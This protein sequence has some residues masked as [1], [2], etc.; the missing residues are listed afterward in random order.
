M[1]DQPHL[2][3][4]QPPEDTSNLEVI[5]A[6]VAAVGVDLDPVEESA[7][8]KLTA[9]G[10]EVVT[11][12]LTRDIIP[13]IT[14][15]TG[16]KP[17]AEFNRYW[18]MMNEGN[19]AREKFGEDVLA[20]GIASEISK[21][22]KM[23]PGHQKKIAYIVRSLKHPKEVVRLRDIYPR[24][25]YL[26]AVQSSAE[27]RR[28]Y[29][30]HKKDMSRTDANKL[31]DRDKKE[32]SDHG[33]HNVD[34][35]HLADFFLCAQDESDKGVA[36]GK[37]VID[38][39][40]NR[41]IDILFGHPNM[42]PTFGEHSMFLAFSSSL[43]SADLSRQVGAVITKNREVLSMGANDCPSPQGGL[44]WPF[45]SRQTL[46]VE[47]VPG[48]R[49]YMR[50]EDSNRKQLLELRKKIFQKA[51]GEFNQVME[52][53]EWRKGLGNKPQL[54]FASVQRDLE[55]ELL[56]SLD[57]LLAKS[58]IAD[59]TEFGRV[60]HAEMEALLSCGRKGIS[61][62]GATLFS[63]TFPCHNC[64]KHI[65]AAG[66]KKVV[67]I[68][69]Y[70]KSKALPLHPD[71]IDIVYPNPMIHDLSQRHGV[72]QFQP[73]V[74][75]GPRRVFDLFSMSLGSGND[76]IRKDDETGDAMPWLQQ[77]AKPRLQMSTLSFLQRETDS[78]QQFDTFVNRC[79]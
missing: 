14:G 65:V 23:F 39:N 59:L 18:E 47:D 74:G 19:D 52:K 54:E 11:I 71:S 4:L 32:S 78:A 55:K 29:L 79:K 2:P 76:V 61:T 45:F 67:F 6:F 51:V 77:Q 66:V 33:Q 35:F 37:A 28:Y 30:M 26:F 60:V 31:M 24:G 38:G 57:N 21:R 69:P 73:F 27:S 43:R 53:G 12:R 62:L 44:Y 70:M 48:G 58:P 7:K 40:M 13:A 22:R 8:R 15:S 63:T 64:A 3:G 75:V 72:V 42:T 68:Q 17:S 34:T 10:Y 20:L 56:I 46:K 41:F 1:N 9:M 5:I 49:D 25:F 50:K 16:A 36:W